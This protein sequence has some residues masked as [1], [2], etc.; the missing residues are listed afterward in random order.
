MDNYDPQLIS[1]FL[2]FIIG[3]MIGFHMLET[4]VTLLIQI[5]GA[6]TCATSSGSFVYILIM[7]VISNVHT[8]EVQ[9]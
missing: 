4:P 7:S 8:K 9:K 1:T 6:I 2:A 5:M 3:N